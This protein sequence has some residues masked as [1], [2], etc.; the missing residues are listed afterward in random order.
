VLVPEPLYRPT[1]AAALAPD[2]VWYGRLAEPVAR[3][4][5][6]RIVAPMRSGRAWT[7]RAGQVARLVTT[8]GPQVVDFNAWN[9][10]DPRERFW[11]ARTKQLHGA[12]MNVFDRLWSCLP[13]LRPMATVI[14]DSIRYGIDADGAGCHDL[15]GTRCDPYVH[16]MLT[17]EDFDYCCHSNLYR[18]VKP[19]GLAES[20][21]HDVLNVFQVTGLTTEGHGYFVKPCPA[22][23]G[24]YFEFFA[25]IDLLCAVST[26]PHGDMSLPIWGENAVADVSSICRPI[27]IEV[28]DVDPE[29]LFGWRSPPVARYHGHHGIEA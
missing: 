20:D 4:L 15:L 16:R 7:M 1:S 6:E 14:G 28:S 12:H 22:K 5:V 29:L 24:D 23:A 3:R 17:G 18:A 21:V 10:H 11:A 2:R 26:C 19:H 25:E 8:D 9:H 27:A 13:Y